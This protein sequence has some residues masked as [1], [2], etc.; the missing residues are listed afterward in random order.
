MQYQSDNSFNKG[1]NLDTNPIAVD[2]DTLTYCLNGTLITYNGN[3]FILQNDMGNGRVETAK[4]PAGYV[5]VGMKEHGGIVYVASTNPHTNESQIGSFPSPEQN[6]TIGE[7][8]SSTSVTVQLSD[9]IS[10]NC[11]KSTRKIDRLTGVLRPGDQFKVATTNTEDTTVYTY[12]QENVEGH[13]TVNLGVKNSNNSITKISSVKP[14]ETKEN[15]SYFSEKTSGELYLISELNVPE[16]FDISWSRPTKSDNG[17]SITFEWYCDDVISVKVGDQICNSTTTADGQSSGTITIDVENSIAN[18]EFIP[19]KNFGE[20]YTQVEIPQLSQTVVIDIETEISGEVNLSTWK[21]TNNTLNEDSVVKLTYGF[22]SAYD[23]DSVQFNFTP[24]SNEGFTYSTENKIDATSRTTYSGVFNQTITNLTLNWLYLVEI[25]CT[26]KDQTTKSF[27][28]WLWT[29]DL[30]NGVKYD[31]E[32]SNVPISIY[33]NTIIKLIGESVENNIP[34]QLTTTKT[35]NE[36]FKQDVTFQQKFNLETEVNVEIPD[37]DD[38]TPFSKD[39]V[40][41]LLKP[42]YEIKVLN[43]SNQ[44]DEFNRSGL[45][46]PRD[47]NIST[48]NVDSITLSAVYSFVADSMQI[49]N[50]G[51]AYQIEKYVNATDYDFIYGSYDENAKSPNYAIGMSMGKN[52]RLLGKESYYTYYE[53]GNVNEAKASYKSEYNKVGKVQR[54]WYNI[55]DDIK[56]KYITTDGLNYIPPITFLTNTVTDN[57][58]LDFRDNVLCVPNDI[59]GPEYV[60][61]YAIV[62]W[63]NG[64][65]YYVLRGFYDN[66]KTAVEKLNALFGDLYVCSASKTELEVSSDTYKANSDEYNFTTENIVNAEVQATINQVLDY[67]SL[68]DVT[69][70]I[71]SQLSIVYREPT[72]NEVA[73]YVENYIMVEDSGIATHVKENGTYRPAGEGEEATHILDGY[74]PVGEGEEATHIVVITLGEK[75]LTHEESKALLESPN[76]KFTANLKTNTVTHSETLTLPRQDIYN[77][78]VVKYFQDDILAPIVYKNGSTLVQTDSNGNSF[79]FDTIYVMD[80]SDKLKPI[81]EVSEFSNI[82]KYLRTSL[83]TKDTETKRCILLNL[84]PGLKKMPKIAANQ[85]LGVRTWNKIPFIGE[86]DIDGYEGTENYP[87]SFIYGWDGDSAYRN[88]YEYLCDI[89]LPDTTLLF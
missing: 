4:L 41:V 62:L 13:I 61:N 15:Y 67:A 68:D 11:V 63:F 83:M 87:F 74:R 18:F 35:K 66:I 8:E 5:P 40:D 70:N 77:E 12:P 24:F 28:R 88:N 48:N 17:Y 36:L 84:S 79:S 27:Y 52:S 76:I 46:L 37:L 72:N 39:D 6:Y 82:S 26:M 86:T 42:E 20:S 80:D 51:T 23:V 3:E 32:N 85:V 25:V 71:V 21:Y 53:I 55:Q 47:Y 73:S 10:D 16:K 30:L 59:G 7:D 19:V 33:S 58:K 57:N 43:T 1:L 89:I 45:Y 49:E 44:F 64:Q 9:F 14:I 81:S 29:N 22:T 75:Q 69:K 38:K 2:N 60:N 54:S 50:L 34:D 56:L 31:F 78:V 65:D